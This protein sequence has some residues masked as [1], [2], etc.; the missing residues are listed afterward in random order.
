[1]V[2]RRSETRLG[3]SFTKFSP[4]DSSLFLSL[5]ALRCGLE[6][7]CWLGVRGLELSPGEEIETTGMGSSRLT[8]GRASCALMMAALTCRNVFV[9][10]VVVW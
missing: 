4:R 3:D 8:S 10:C 1:M 2:I 9:L 7:W 5:L 6:A